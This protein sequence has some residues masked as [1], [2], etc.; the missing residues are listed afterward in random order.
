[1]TKPMSQLNVWNNA[2]ALLPVVIE[3]N[4]GSAF[5]CAQKISSLGL[6]VQDIS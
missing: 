6:S 5:V 3:Q 4:I 2:F 1:M